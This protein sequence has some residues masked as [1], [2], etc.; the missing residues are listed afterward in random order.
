MITNVEYLSH[1]RTISTM[2]TGHY[3]AEYNETPIYV[4]VETSLKR[5]EFIK[6]WLCHEPGH[7]VADIPKAYVCWAVEGK[8]EQMTLFK[9]DIQFF[10]CLNDYLNRNNPKL[11][12]I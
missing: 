10:D 2:M 1:L 8:P 7:M 11:I 5:E 12:A 4:V 6:A 3:T 9:H